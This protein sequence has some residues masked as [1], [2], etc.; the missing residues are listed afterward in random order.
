VNLLVTVNTFILYLF[1]RYSPLTAEVK[2][3]ALATSEARH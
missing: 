3:H 2:I 1:L